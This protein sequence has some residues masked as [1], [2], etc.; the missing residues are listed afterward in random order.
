M[1]VVVPD[2]VSGWE[3]AGVLQGSVFA[4]LEVANEIP[5]VHVICM[6]APAAFLV[7]HCRLSIVVVPTALTVPEK[8]CTT[9]SGGSTYPA[10]VNERVLPREAS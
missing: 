5:S 10:T 2:E 1:S 9:G 7:A 3:N 4:L 8:L 6:F